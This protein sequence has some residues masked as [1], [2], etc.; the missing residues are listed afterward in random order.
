MRHTHH[1]SHSASHELLV[2]HSL[3]A[4]HAQLSV[5]QRHTRHM[6]YTLDSAS[7]ASHAPFS[8]A[9]R[10]MLFSASRCVTRIT[11]ASRPSTKV[12]PSMGKSIPC[13]VVK[14]HF[15]PSTWR[16]VKKNGWL[17]LC[18][19]V[20]A[21]PSASFCKHLCR[22]WRT[23]LVNI[24]FASIFVSIWQ[25]MSCIYINAHTHTHVK[26]ENTALAQ[27]RTTFSSKEPREQGDPTSL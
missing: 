13:C 7:H 4:S 25:S 27:I 18:H 22:G 3:H 15:L 23:Y 2:S 10:H 11:Y 21:V 9:L 5:A 24:Y 26:I 1:T 8:V 6:L 19:H 14:S 16:K 20:P 17:L 12:L